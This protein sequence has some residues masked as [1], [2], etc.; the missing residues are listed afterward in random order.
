VAR[1]KRLRVGV[2]YGGRSGEHEVSLASAAAVFANV[3]RQR[4]EPV[5]IRI[6]RD[7]RW[8][9]ADRPPS[10]ASA[11]DVIQ[12]VRSD[13]A[14]VRGGR[15]VFLPPRPGDETL[16]LVDR[17]PS[18]ENDGES[19]AALTGLSLDV[20][21]PVLHGPYGEDGTIQGLLE[22]AN[23]PYVGCGVLAS[24]VG[25]DKA[26][27]KELFRSRGLRVADGLT[28]RRRDWRTAPAA[29]TATIDKSM[30]YPLFVKPANL[31]SSVGISKVHHAAELAPAL[32][33][34]AEFDR[35]IIVELAVADAREIE[36][37]VLGNDEPEAS[38]PG[39]VV[40]SREFYD[41]EAK[42]ID[43]GSRL[44]IPAQLEPAVAREVRRQAIVAFDAIDGTGLAR[45]DFLL[46]RSSGDLYV[47][48]IN[49]LPGF[50]TI[51]MF[52]KLW[53]ASGLDYPVL[54]DRLITLAIERHADKQQSKTSAL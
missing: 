4:Y 18:R 14:R 45:V 50:T 41:Y 19:S 3:D 10:A 31:G 12:Q 40:P 39:E 47:N 49:S 20:I 32:D 37:A 1:A 25:M 51:S 53:Q 9:L 27:M 52:S 15:E 22:L 8:V 16:V 48:E 5:P 11:A 33:L 2:L 6:E 34:A 42:Y 36:C 23:V 35:K 24:A 44:E 7:G 17:R 30:T 38:V 54:V 13:V 43:S 28:V 46:S 29:V 21:F 26:V